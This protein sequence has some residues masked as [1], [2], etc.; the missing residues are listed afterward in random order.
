MR[1]IVQVRKCVV[2]LVK[3]VEMK[4]VPMK[5]TVYIVDKIITLRR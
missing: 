3:L 5:K 4:I 2:H 1:K